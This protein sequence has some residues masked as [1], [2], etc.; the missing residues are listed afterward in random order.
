MDPD[1]PFDQLPDN[2][3]QRDTLRQATPDREPELVGKIDR[4]GG[5]L[6]GSGWYLIAPY[7]LYSSES[8]L[9]AFDRCV[10]SMQ[11]AHGLYRVCF[12]VSAR[13]SPNKKSRKYSRDT[14]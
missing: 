10:L 4:F 6:D 5:F 1:G 2:L 8:D 9:S 14:R 12:D 3:I 7:L 13:G 11:A